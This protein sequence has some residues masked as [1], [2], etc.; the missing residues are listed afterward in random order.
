MSSLF[1]D[2]VFPNKVLNRIYLMTNVC[3]KLLI[4]PMTKLNRTNTYFEPNT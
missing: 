4:S 2:E 1:P 3:M